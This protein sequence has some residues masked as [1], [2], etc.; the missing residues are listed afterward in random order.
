V[1]GLAGVLLLAAILWVTMGSFMLATMSL[2]IAERAF[3]VTQGSFPS[4]EQM[5]SFRYAMIFPVALLFHLF[6]VNVVSL[7][8]YPALCGIG[9][10]VVAFFLGKILFNERVGFVAA[11]LLSFYPLNIRLSTE[12]YS[13]NPGA[14][15]MSLTVLLYVLGDR[16][17]SHRR[18]VLLYVLSG[19]SL[20]LSFLVR[21]SAVILAL[22]FAVDV[23]RQKRITWPHV[24]IASVFLLVLVADAVVAHHLAGNW[25]QR[26]DVFRSHAGMSPAVIASI[27]DW[28]YLYTFAIPLYEHGFFYYLVGAGFIYLIVKRPPN[29][30]LPLSWFFALFAY[31]AWGHLV[32]RYSLGVQLSRY[33]AAIAVPAVLIIA[34]FLDQNRHRLRGWSTHAAVVF[35]FVTSLFAA[36]VIREEST[37]SYFQIREILGDDPGKAVYSNLNTVRA[38]RFLYG[39]QLDDMFKR[40]DDDPEAI[41]AN[42]AKDSFVV[43][44]RHWVQMAIGRGWELVFD[45][46]DPP[47]SWERYAQIDN[48]SRK[49]S[50]LQARLMAWVGRLPVWPKALGARLVEE[51]TGVL[52]PGDAVIYRTGAEE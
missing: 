35:L 51:S 13:D 48:P 10:I 28:F 26:Y 37:R 33:L 46:E 21:E 20:G 52:E 22:F 40:Y 45:W 29:S 4:L 18:A 15:F 42:V 30:W 8:L 5:A 2:H 14:F 16:T 31:L 50:Y 11:L 1:V 38:L 27:G 47:G 3:Q 36:N 9:L 6:G 12:L 23:L 49:A 44:D 17:A 43:V 25:L 34:V 19:L 39:Y 7:T 41:G 32:T 24:C